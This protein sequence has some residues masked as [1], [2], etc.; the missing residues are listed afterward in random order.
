MRWKAKGHIAA[1]I[2]IY[3]ISIK[4]QYQ[5]RARSSA[6]LRKRR[7][8]VRKNN[9]VSR[10]ARKTKYHEKV[11]HIA[12]RRAASFISRTLRSVWRRN[13][14]ISFKKGWRKL[15]FS[16]LFENVSISANIGRSVSFVAATATALVY[17]HIISYKCKIS[18]WKKRKN[19][20]LWK[21]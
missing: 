2:S 15:S 12:A 1:F 8:R 9:G 21:T 20:Y 3:H 5:Q 19:I 13:H 16:Y 14:N 11:K 17:P 7:H 6:C 4:R 10:N 18:F